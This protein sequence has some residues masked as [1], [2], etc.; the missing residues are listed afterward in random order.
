M[1]FELARFS[2]YRIPG[3]LIE[4][5]SLQFGTQMTLGRVVPSA[6][7]YQGEALDPNALEGK[8][9]KNTKTKIDFSLIGFQEENV[10]SGI[11][12]KDGVTNTAHVKH[13]S[14]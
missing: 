10:K 6:Q 3:Q 7:S 2:E 9:L 12:F 1:G 13:C 8:F 4:I 14:Q 11:P 5:C